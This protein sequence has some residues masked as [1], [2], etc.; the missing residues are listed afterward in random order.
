MS[1][2]LLLTFG[3]HTLVDDDI[4]E[5]FKNQKLYSHRRGSSLQTAGYYARTWDIPGKRKHLLHRLIMKAQPGQEVDHINGDSLDNR[6]E[7]L[8]IVDKSRNQRNQRKSSKP[9]SSKFK[10]VAWYKNGN[11]WRAQIRI[12]DRVTHLGY[13]KD[14]IEAARA[15][16][17]A[18]AIQYKEYACLNVL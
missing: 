13:F 1:K 3:L 11:C 16:N 12:D 6:R 4:Y 8:R 14:E 9:M 17:Q 2:Y 10:G 5:Q 15:Y 7:N 18:A